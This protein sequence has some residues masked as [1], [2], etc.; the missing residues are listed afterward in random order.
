MKFLSTFLV[1]SFSLTSFASDYGFTTTTCVSATGRTTAVIAL[2]NDALN[3]ISGNAVL[4]QDGQPVNIRFTTNYRGLIQRGR[5]LVVT[6]N[7]EEHFRLIGVGASRTL[8]VTKDTR[9]DTFARI[10][11]KTEPQSIPVSCRTMAHEP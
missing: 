5:N 6:Q 3:G 10:N 11:A 8:V 4:L 1:L 7:G 2:S 9:L